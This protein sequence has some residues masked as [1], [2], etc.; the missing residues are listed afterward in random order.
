MESETHEILD[1]SKIIYSGKYFK[2]EDVN[3]LIKM[4]EEEEKDSKIDIFL[5][6]SISNII[7]QELINSKDS[8]IFLSLNK[9]E[10]SED[11]NFKKIANSDE[12]DN[13]NSYSCSLIAK[14]FSPRYHVSSMDDFFWEKL[15][16]FN[17]NDNNQKILSRF[18]N[19]AFV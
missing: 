8:P 17:T 19:I 5:S 1:Y 16:Y 3:E 7:F 12:L 2:R 15:N 11:M 18:I 6:H 14:I 9:K 13:F 10:F 4:K